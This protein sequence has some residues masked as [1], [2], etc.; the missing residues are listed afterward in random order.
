MIIGVPKEIKAQEN[1]VSVTPAA[2]YQLIRRGHQVLVEKGAGSGSGFPDEAYIKT[3]AELIGNHAEVFG[4][5][6]M[7]VKVKEPLESEYALLRQG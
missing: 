4:R 1:R 3:G 2:A 5:A 6:E 7:V